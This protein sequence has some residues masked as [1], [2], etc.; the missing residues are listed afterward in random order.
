MEKRLQS[1]VEVNDESRRLKRAQ[2]DKGQGK[3]RAEKLA[4]EPECKP[5]RILIQGGIWKKLLQQPMN[6]RLK[7]K[8]YGM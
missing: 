1:F 5:E 7:R 3:N 2:D 4:F 8:A 6:R